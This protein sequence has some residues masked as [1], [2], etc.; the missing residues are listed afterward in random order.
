MELRAQ[1]FTTFFSSLLFISRILFSSFPSIKGPFFSDLGIILSELEL[2]TLLF[3]LA[4]ANDKLAGRL[5]LVSGL[6][7][8]S[9][10]SPWRLWML[11]T[12]T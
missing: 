6:Q 4:A 7:T 12:T 9:K 11:A 10:L 5:L 8:F 2:F 3:G 1:V